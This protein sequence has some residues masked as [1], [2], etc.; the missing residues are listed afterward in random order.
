[1]PSIVLFPIPRFFNMANIFFLARTW[2]WDNLSKTYFPN[3]PISSS[4]SGC[5]F[6][7][8]TPYFSLVWSCNFLGKLKVSGNKNIFVANLADEVM[9]EDLRNIFQPHGKVVSVRIILDK[10]TKRSRGFGFVEM[11]TYIQAKA[12]IKALDGTK[13]LGK[14]IAV[15]EA[16]S[17]TESYSGR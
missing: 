1:M 10:E 6:L 5:F 16:R 2:L 17:Q 7:F 13:L 12:A 9:N 8:F 14:S 11:E 3:Y 4:I 15:K